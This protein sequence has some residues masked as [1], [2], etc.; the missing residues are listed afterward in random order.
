MEWMPARE[1]ADVAAALVLTRVQLSGPDWV[2]KP[3]RAGNVAG[4]GVGPHAWSGALETRKCQG[5]GRW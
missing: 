5:G 1:T 4:P 2:V 3:L